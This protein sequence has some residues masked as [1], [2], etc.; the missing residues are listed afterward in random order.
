MPAV[1]VMEPTVM[2]NL[3]HPLSP[4]SIIACRLVDF[5]VQGKITGADTLT[6]HLDTTPSGIS[7]PP[8]PIIPHF[9]TEC[10]FCYNPPISSWLG[11]TLNKLACI[12]GGLVSKV[13]TDQKYK[14]V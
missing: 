3:L 2:Q 5:M 1:L 11:Q 6:I 10:S 7:V 8:P 14:V 13:R 9:Y 12:S 4:L